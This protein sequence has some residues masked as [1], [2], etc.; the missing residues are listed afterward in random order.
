[1]LEKPIC[2][3][4]PR[5]FESLLMT[6]HALP[7]SNY[8]RANLLA[9]GL[10]A[11]PQTTIDSSRQTMKITN[12]SVITWFVATVAWGIAVWFLISTTIFPQYTPPLYRY[13]LIG[14]AATCIL[15]RFAVAR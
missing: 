12:K 5:P 7:E 3:P 11:K 13:I 1:M 4:Q 8:P 6:G 9:E 10:S 15:I 2:I 14:I